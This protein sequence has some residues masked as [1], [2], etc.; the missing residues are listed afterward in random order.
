MA[1][2]Q[3]LT[4]LQRLARMVNSISKF[5]SNLAEVAAPP[6]ALLKKDIFFN[7]EKPQLD[8]IEKL[9]TLI[10]SVPILKIFYSN[11]PT[12]IK[13]DAS[14]EGLSA[15]LEQNHGSLENRK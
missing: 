1:V 10:K 8:A 12:R 11:L 13:L 5:I 4:E 9:K 7:L 2:P 15:L 6:R 3:S 14:S